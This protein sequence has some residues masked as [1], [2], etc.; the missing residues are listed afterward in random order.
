MYRAE[1]VMRKQ[2]H[3]EGTEMPSMRITLDERERHVVGEE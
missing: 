2:M 1:R 3:T